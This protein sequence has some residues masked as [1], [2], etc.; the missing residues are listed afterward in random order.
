M[1]SRIGVLAFVLASLAAAQQSAPPAVLRHVGIDQKLNQ[2]VPLDLPF[3]D[4]SGRRVEIGQYLGKRPVVLALVYYQCPMLCNLVLNGMVHSLEKISLTP[5]KDYEMVTV[6]FDSRETHQMAAAKKKNY[7]EKFDRPGVADGWHFLTG[8]DGP[9]RKLAD[10]VGFRYT[11][12]PLT[13]QF[14]HAAAIMVLTPDGR[15]ARYFFGVDYNPQDVRLGLVEASDNKIGTPVDQLLLYC[16]H[17][18]PSRGKYGFVIMNVI[19]AV[20]SA[21]VL[22]LGTFIFVML[23]RDS[24]KK[25]GPEEA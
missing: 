3:V 13:N 18:D 14:A 16:F 15:V 8:D 10:S 12:D 7:V 17:Y 11:Y 4:E 9:I 21:T 1:R 22:A 5:G 19:R 20:G 25:H 2:Q 24:R 6:S 23:R